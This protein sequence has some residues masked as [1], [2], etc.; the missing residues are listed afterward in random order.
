MVLIREEC[1]D[2]GLQGYATVSLAEQFHFKALWCVHLERLKTCFFFGLLHPVDEG[3]TALHNVRSCSLNSVVS[4]PVQPES[5]A[6]P[7][8]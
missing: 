4:R 6:P 1:D 2:L 8:W 5:S 3:T 7:L